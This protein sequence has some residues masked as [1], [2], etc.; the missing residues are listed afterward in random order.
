M[1]ATPKTME[2]PPVDMVIFMPDIEDESD[3]IKTTNAER[4]PWGSSN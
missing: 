1:L 4:K 2:F 3:K